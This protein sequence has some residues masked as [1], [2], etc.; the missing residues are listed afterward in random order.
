MM[1]GLTKK[2][3][4]QQVADAAW[5]RH[6][7]RSNRPP[8]SPPESVL[9][10]VPY[11]LPEPVEERKIPVPLPCDPVV[12][13]IALERHRASHPPDSPEPGSFSEAEILNQIE[14]LRAAEKARDEVKHSGL[15]PGDT[16]CY[17][18]RI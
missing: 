12:A 1:A 5:I 18:S 9:R 16:V 10:S 17:A 11:D 6:Q 13:G 15:R 14:E 8:V 4:E 7:M 2:E 3:R